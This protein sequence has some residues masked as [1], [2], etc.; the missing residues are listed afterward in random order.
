M[1]PGQFS[2]LF[3]LQ[4]KIYTYIHI[5]IIKKPSKYGIECEM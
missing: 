2:I 1:L 5:Y 4:L 3:Y